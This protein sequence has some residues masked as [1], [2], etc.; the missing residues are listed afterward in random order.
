MS[1]ITLSFF[2]KEPRNHYLPAFNQEQAVLLLSGFVPAPGT[3][4]SDCHVRLRTAHTTQPVRRYAVTPL[5]GE[6]SAVNLL[7][8]KV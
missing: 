4:S 6:I 8:L 2:I 7:E 5:Y 3:V 1:F